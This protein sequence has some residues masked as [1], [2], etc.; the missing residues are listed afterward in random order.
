MCVWTLDF[1]EWG[2]GSLEGF[3]CRLF[4]NLFIIIFRTLH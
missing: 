2:V 3:L 1:G 4:F